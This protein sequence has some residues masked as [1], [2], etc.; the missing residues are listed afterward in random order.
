MEDKDKNRW[1]VQE[2]GA[3]FNLKKKE[4]KSKEPTNREEILLANIH[5]GASTG[6][7]FTLRGCMGWDGRILGF[8]LL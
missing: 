6:I 8:C 2:N 4:S 3:S 1:T 5:E 7:Y